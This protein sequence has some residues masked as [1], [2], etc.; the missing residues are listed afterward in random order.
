MLQVGKKQKLVVVKEVG[1]GVYLGE[2]IENTTSEESVLLPKKEVPEGLKRGD[3]LEVFLYLDSEDRKI[4]TLREP[5]F[6]L[7]GLA[8]LA[9]IEVAEVGAFLDW[10]LEKDL[11]LPFKEQTR[12]VQAGEEVFVA[13]YLDKSSR[14][15]A[16]MN[17]YEYLQTDSPY[18]K[19][20][21]VNGTIYQISDEF[22]V[23]VAVDNCYSGLIPKQEAAGTYQ[24]GSQIQVRVTSVKLD[25]KLDLSDRE[26]KEIQMDKDAQQ[27]LEVMETHY[28]GVLPF[29]EKVSPQIIKSEFGISKAAFKRAVGRLYK[30]RLIEISENSIKRIN[31]NVLLYKK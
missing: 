6:M 31:K 21:Y 20:D 13:L 4:A 29:G 8:T 16:T 27:I 17:V 25:G 30:Q 10:G 11:L 22:G 1:F 9:V 18:Q 24:V 23:F 15:C 26:K 14:L 7:G 3:E 12:K 28:G 19:D 5:I 2:E